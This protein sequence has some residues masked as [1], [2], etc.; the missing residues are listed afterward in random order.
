MIVK[1]QKQ[2]V[3]D[4]I[5]AMTADQLFNEA[6]TLIASTISGY[7][8][9]A[10]IIKELDDRG[11]DLTR[12]QNNPL[13]AILRKVGHGQLALEAVASLPKAVLRFV[14]RLPLPLQL[15]AAK[16]TVKYTIVGLRQDGQVYKWQKPACEMSHR[17]AAT[18]FSED[19]VRNEEQQIQHLRSLAKPKYNTEKSARV[20]IDKKRRGLTISIGAESVFVSESELLDN[21]AKLAS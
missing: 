14:S 7:R 3:V 6:E 9:L 12:L 8:R 19:A 4:G 13:F 18:V 17:E 10:E 5:K 21:L 2:N 20:A 11:E 15:E 16:P 1:Q